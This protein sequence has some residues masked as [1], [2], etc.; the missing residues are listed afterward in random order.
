MNPA[1]VEP[2]GGSG[3][4]TDLSDVFGGGPTQP[5]AAQPTAAAGF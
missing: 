1:P 4:M 5:V 2:V 3:L